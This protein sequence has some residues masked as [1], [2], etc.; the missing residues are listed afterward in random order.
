MN[1][2]HD[3]ELVEGYLPEEILNPHFIFPTCTDYILYYQ[4]F[5][6]LN[7]PSH[8]TSLIGIEIELPI[9]LSFSSIPQKEAQDI[10]D[11]LQLNKNKPLIL[12]QKIFFFTL[13]NISESMLMK[14]LIPLLSKSKKMKYQP[15][16]GIYVCHPLTPPDD[17]IFYTL[18]QHKNSKNN[19]CLLSLMNS[20]YLVSR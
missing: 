6:T 1:K 13:F 20:H 12:K 10:K 7:K 16:I 14:R 5:K 9:E 19:N 3:F 4:Y 18:N 11:I 2:E 17:F 8:V 15:I